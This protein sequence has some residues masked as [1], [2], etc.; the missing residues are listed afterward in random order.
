MAAWRGGGQKR[1][2][3]ARDRKKRA[4]KA[5]DRKKRALKARDRKVFH[6]CE[7]HRTRLL[8]VRRA[9][10]ASS[11]ACRGLNEPLLCGSP[12]GAANRVA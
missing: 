1:A 11:P 5:R 7:K 9:L 2:L 10:A 3:K 8:T 4:L 6:I 12:V